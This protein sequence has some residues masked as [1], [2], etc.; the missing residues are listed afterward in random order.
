MKKN[1]TKIALFVPDLRIG[2]AEKGFVKIAN[3]LIS[4]GYN[5]DLITFLDKVDLAIYLSPKVRVIN[6]HRRSAYFTLF[7][8]VRYMIQSKP[9]ALLSVL[10]LTNLIAILA[11]IISKQKTIV[12]I[13]IVN[14]T[15]MQR[16]TKI[17]KWLERL[18]LRLL[19]PLADH[20]IANANDVVNDLAKYLNMPADK[21][22]MQYIPTTDHLLDELSLEPLSHPW[23][24]LDSP[25]VILGVGRLV[26]QKNFG[27]L[28][29]SFAIVRQ[30][31]E[32]NLMII[33]DGEQF[34]M[35]QNKVKN[36]GLQEQVEFVGFNINPYP[37]VKNAALLAVPSN[38]DGLS[39]ILVEAMYLRTPVI[40]TDCIS[41]PREV[42]DHGK[43]GTLVPVGDKDALADGLMDIIKGNYQVV[44]PSWL[45]QFSVEH[46]V[47]QLIKKMGIREIPDE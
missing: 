45:K 27:L 29:E 30:Q 8:L 16:R 43:Y 21:I 39:M 2:G 32:S 20:I 17:K 1:K 26:E 40:C 4:L 15:S 9:T 41:G 19:Y 12:S 13:Y 31:I 5:V 46:G 25:S 36:L 6:F 7:P 10:D 44:D 33:G 28:I 38:W 47:P 42:L 24:Q 22:L 35:L 23:F 3:G 37:Y 18:F 14:N 11:K 34:D